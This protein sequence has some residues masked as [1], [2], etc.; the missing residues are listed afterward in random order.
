MAFYGITVNFPIQFLAE[1]W[2][3]MQLNWANLYLNEPVVFQ[4]VKNAI[5]PKILHSALTIRYQVQS[6]MLGTI[7]KVVGQNIFTMSCSAQSYLEK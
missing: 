1:F 5:E 2:S 7:M 3:G 6:H 4:H